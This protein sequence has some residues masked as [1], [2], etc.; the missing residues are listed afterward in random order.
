[1]V[2]PLCVAIEVRDFR[3]REMGTILKNLIF[4]LYISLII[5]ISSFH[6][7]I[8]CNAYLYLFNRIVNAKFYVILHQRKAF[9]CTYLKEKKKKNIALPS[10]FVTESLRRQYIL[11]C[12]YFIC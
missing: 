6:L 12:L 10:S 3:K 5:I 7:C 4:V 9:V 1:M 2:Q 11:T 8:I